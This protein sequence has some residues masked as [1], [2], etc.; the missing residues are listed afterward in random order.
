MPGI[1]IR[2]RDRL[3]DSGLNETRVITHLSDDEQFPKIL[4]IVLNGAIADTDPAFANSAHH[5][6]PRSPTLS[7]S[8]V[9]QTRRD[10][11]HR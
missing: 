2:C 6:V 7:H 1:I 5:S 4:D 10:D 3:K 11:A 8:P 9:Q